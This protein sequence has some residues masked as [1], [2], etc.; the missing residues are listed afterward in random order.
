[1]G[2]GSYQAKS[3]EELEEV[4]VDAPKSEV[5]NAENSAKVADSEVEK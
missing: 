3:F 2:M 4:V 5:E 1:M